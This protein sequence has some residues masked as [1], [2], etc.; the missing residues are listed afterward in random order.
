ML[1]IYLT[2][3]NTKLKVFIMCGHFFKF[4]FRK[5]RKIFVS[6]DLKSIQFT[7]I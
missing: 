6:K 1:N 4:D 2:A 3:L 5:M 7:K